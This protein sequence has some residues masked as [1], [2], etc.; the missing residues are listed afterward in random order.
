MQKIKKIVKYP[1][2]ENNNNNK[3]KKSHNVGVKNSNQL[4]GVKFE[5]ITKKS[6]SKNPLKEL[7]Q[8]LY[9]LPSELLQK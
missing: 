7:N 9:L 2:K 3:Q 1:K 6:R 4:K 5:L 8:A